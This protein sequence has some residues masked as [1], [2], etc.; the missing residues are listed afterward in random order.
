MK[1]KNI[2]CARDKIVF[3]VSDRPGKKTM[4]EFSFQ[5]PTEINFGSGKIKEIGLKVSTCLENL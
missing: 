1:S 2:E 4:I 3:S 5:M